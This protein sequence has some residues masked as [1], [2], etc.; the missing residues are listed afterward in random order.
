MSLCCVTHT[1]EVR[2]PCNVKPK[3]N[4]FTGKAV[5]EVAVHGSCLFL[6]L[7]LT[8]VGRTKTWTCGTY[9]DTFSC[10]ISNLV[11]RFIES[12]TAVPFDVSKRHLCGATCLIH[13]H[14]PALDE[15]H[16]GT[17]SALPPQH[18]DGEFTVRQEVQLLLLA[19]MTVAN[20]AMIAEGSAA[21]MVLTRAPSYGGCCV[22]Q[23]SNQSIESL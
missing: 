9:L 23:K 13:E 1:L 6:I 21:V 3:A 11:S 2:A 8:C 12:K 20:V 4:L 19:R 14:T 5:C 18:C 17:S 22:P 10:C 15:L 7:P 16:N